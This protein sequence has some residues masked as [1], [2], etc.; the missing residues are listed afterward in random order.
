[1]DYFPGIYFLVVLCSDGLGKEIIT[2]YDTD[3]ATDSTFFT[4]SNGRELQKRVLVLYIFY[5]MYVIFHI[6]FRRNFRPTWKYNNTEPVSGNYYPVN[7][8]IIIEVCMH[9]LMC[10]YTVYSYT[11]HHRMVIN[12]SVY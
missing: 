9:V 1:M 8:R 6:I 3:M 2:R 5:Y 4:D 7:S 10:K 11:L 12:G